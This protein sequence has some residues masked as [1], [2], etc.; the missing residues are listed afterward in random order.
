M[1]AEINRRQMTAKT[2]KD[3]AVCPFY[4]K[5]EQQE[6]QDRR[7]SQLLETAENIALNTCRLKLQTFTC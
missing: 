3:P 4:S 6:Q 1:Y 7:S 5:I 2:F